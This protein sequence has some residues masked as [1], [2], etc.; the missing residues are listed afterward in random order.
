MTNLKKYDDA[1]VLMVMKEVT[2][3]KTFSEITKTHDV[4]YAAL[5]N[6]CKKL[7]VTPVRGNQRL[8]HDWEAIKAQLA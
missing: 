4:T 2:S 7:G 6:W 5:A 3:G 8:R 1:F